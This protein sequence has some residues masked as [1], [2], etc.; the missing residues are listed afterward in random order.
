MDLVLSASGIKQ[1]RSIGA[2]VQDETIAGCHSLGG[3]PVARLHDD[4]VAV[5]QSGVDANGTAN[6]DALTRLGVDRHKLVA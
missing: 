3:A 4:L 6:E 1:A 5:R 2:P